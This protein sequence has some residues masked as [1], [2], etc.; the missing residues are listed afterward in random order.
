MSTESQ[1]SEAISFLESFRGGPLT[2]GRM[3]ESFRKCDEVTQEQL[4]R[5]MRM[6][7]AHLCDIEK[8]RRMVSAERAA[9]FA[10][11][12]GY[13]VEQFVAVA[14]EDQ[15]RKAGIKLKVLLKAA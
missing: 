11:V 14:I 3:I 15:L 5:K 7:K 4:A 12:M 10:R 2:F 9:R 13:M 1:K 8:G 6:S